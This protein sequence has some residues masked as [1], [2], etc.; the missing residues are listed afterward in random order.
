[1]HILFSKVYKYHHYHHHYHHHYYYHY[2]CLYDNR[3]ELVEAGWRNEEENG[4]GIQ[5]ARVM[6]LEPDDKE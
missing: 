2:Y 3:E 5:T 1:M 4:E 6:L